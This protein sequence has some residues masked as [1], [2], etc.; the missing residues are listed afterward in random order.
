MAKLS[1][2]YETC[3]SLHRGRLR[4][5]VAGYDFGNIKTLGFT[6]FKVRFEYGA[7]GRLSE[8]VV[9]TFGLT[10]Q[11]LALKI[12]RDTKTHKVKGDELARTSLIPFPLSLNVQTTS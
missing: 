11:S 9:G 7:D 10:I 3:N 2:E 6:G 5:Y 8:V 12:D 1:E 4:W